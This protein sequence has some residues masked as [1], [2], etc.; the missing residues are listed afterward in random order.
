MSA[1]YLLLSI[2]NKD[3]LYRGQKTTS[4]VSSFSFTLFEIGSLNFSSVHAS[5]YGLYASEVYIS[6]SPV[7]L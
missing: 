2:V 6:L 5:L 7:L 1:E 4:D 3:G